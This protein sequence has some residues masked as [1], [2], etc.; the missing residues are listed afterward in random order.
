[1]AAMGRL[2]KPWQALRLALV[3]SH[4]RSDTLIAATDIGLV[5]DILFARME[6]ARAAIHAFYQSD[7][8]PDALLDKLSDFTLISSAIAAEV[9]ILRSGRWGKR[10]LANRSA[11][12]SVMEAY[13]D[14]A[15][16]EIAAVL[17]LRHNDVGTQTTIPDLSADLDEAQADRAC[18]Y[19]RLIVGCR[20]IASA[21]SFA[22]KFKTVSDA[23]VDLVCRYDDA[24]LAAF[25]AATNEKRAR[26]QERFELAAEMSKILLGRE[27]GELFIRRGALVLAA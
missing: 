18:R 15:G 21:A 24:I 5:G 1:V 10:L 9:D 16:R 7:F 11:V 20:Y 14:R 8:D 4:R 17:P 19:A 3:V 13:L 25:G 12:A 27:E 22:N 26:I 6:D 23:T 2:E